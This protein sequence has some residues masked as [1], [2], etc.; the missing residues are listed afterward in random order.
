MKVIVIWFL[1]SKVFRKRVH[2]VSHL[3]LAPK[4]C[5]YF[6][7]SLWLW[8]ATHCI[9]VTVV[10]KCVCFSF[11]SRF[12]CPQHNLQCVSCPVT[13]LQQP[14]WWRFGHWV[15]AEALGSLHLL[16]LGPI[17][18]EEV[19]HCSHSSV[20]QLFEPVPCLMWWLTWAWNNFFSRQKVCCGIIYK[21]RF[22]EVIIDPRLFK[23]CCSS[24]KQKTLAST[25][26]AAHLPSTLPA[27]L[28]EDV[29]PNWWLL[30]QNPC[31]VKPWHPPSFV[32]SGR[33]PHFHSSN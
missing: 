31:R 12:R 20:R 5:K 28:P 2:W 15:E 27:Q 3:V 21:G 30:F 32:S 10:V 1:S 19:G 22:G 29:K 9:I 23:P 33:P 26:V 14:V 4:Q 24:K 8:A 6:K 11:P 13:Q 17:L 16:L 25:Q 18:L 7:I